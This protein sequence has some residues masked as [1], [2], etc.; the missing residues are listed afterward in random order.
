MA[1]NFSKN[2][3]FVGR[4]IKKIR[5]VKKISQA[6]FAGLFHLSRPSIGAYEEGRSEPK[7]ETLILIATYFKLSIDLLLTREL[8][9]AEIFSLDT[10]KKK[11]DKAHNVGHN[12]SII[13]S[14]PLVSQD[15]FLNYVVNHNSN[16]FID[17]LPKIG[18][19][20][21]ASS[22]LICFEM[23]GSEMVFQ[24]QGL[25]N[26]DLLIGK[27]VHQTD[28]KGMIGQVLCLVTKSGIST[29]RLDSVNPRHLQLKSDDPNYPIE[30]LLS[31]NIIQI[32]QVLG[33]FSEKINPPNYL[34][35]RI[36][37]LEQA[38]D[39]LSTLPES[40]NN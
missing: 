5:Q 38:I 29:K 28:L 23:V 17:K 4:N 35:G 34:E 22:Y 39:K 3:S 33:V 6:E 16:D 1:Q 15:Q 32:W 9:I 19:P 37:K 26:G 8:S 20:I 7:I 12:S 21:K 14:A 13:V 2:L 31:E 11:L 18:I 36:L 10:I 30:D 25:H 24:Q 40:N 27:L